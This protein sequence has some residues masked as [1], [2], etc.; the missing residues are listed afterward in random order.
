MEEEE[1]REDTTK[2]GEFVCSTYR[3]LPIE[4]QK[5]KAEKLSTITD[6]SKNTKK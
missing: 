5:E 6:K 1:R 2:Y 3:W 4:V